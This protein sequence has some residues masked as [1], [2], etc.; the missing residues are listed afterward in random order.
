MVSVY[1]VV[2]LLSHEVVFLQSGHLEP[3]FCVTIHTLVEPCLISDIW[4]CGFHCAKVS[5]RILFNLFPY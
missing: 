4:Q 3:I 5:F 1:S 2:I